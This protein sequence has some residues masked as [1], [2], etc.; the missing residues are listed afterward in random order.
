[1]GQVIAS[2]NLKG[3]TG[4]TTVAVNLACA[5]AASGR[6]VVLL[7]LDP[8]GSASAWAKGGRLP[9]EVVQEPALQIR[10]GG[11]WQA[12]A[13]DLARSTDVVLDLPPVLG[14]AIAGA[15]MIADLVLL[16]ITPSALDVGPTAEALRLLRITREA[17][18]GTRPKALLVANKVDRRGRYDEATQRAVEGLHEPW[19]PVLSH[20]TMHVNAFSAGRW[21]GEYAPGS[22]SAGEVEAL[23]VAVERL[24][25]PGLSTVAAKPDRAKLAAL[26]A[27]ASSR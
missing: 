27:P 17:R 7:D 14:P 13:V 20:D 6:R 18:G 25:A 12:R 9:V 2:A 23:R 10:G 8:Q 1:M 16:P 24:L 26:Q 19:A 5:L 15:F 21:V 22:R 4:K 11:R 3:G